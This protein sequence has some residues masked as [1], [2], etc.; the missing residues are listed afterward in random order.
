MYNLC[1]QGVHVTE[2]RIFRC[3][4]IWS[5]GG[6]T[7]G[8]DLCL[9]FISSVSGKVEAGKV[10]LLLEY[11]PS[12]T[13]YVDLDHVKDLPPIRTPDG[14]LENGMQKLPQYALEEYFQ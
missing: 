1:L 9:A 13:N 10:Q 6:V 8:L 5:S 7:S 4:K 2:R 11:F 3:G 14:L 12:T